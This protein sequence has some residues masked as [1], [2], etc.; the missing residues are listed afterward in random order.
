M[1]NKIKLPLCIYVGLKLVM[2]DIILGDKTAM[3][4]PLVQVLIWE[5]V[6][7]NKGLGKD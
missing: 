2:R 5:L 7:N 6:M 3:V 4:G 1:S